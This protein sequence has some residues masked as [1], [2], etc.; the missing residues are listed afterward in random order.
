MK[1]QHTKTSWISRR[2]FAVGAAAGLASFALPRPV[3][4]QSRRVIAATGIDAFFT[5]FPIARDHKLFEKQG[6]DFTYRTFE[7]STIGLD[8]VL[9]NNADMGAATPSSGI[10]RWDRGGKLY[11]VGRMN[12]S[13]TLYA[14]AGSKD[15]RQPEDLYGK[16]VAFPRL[17]SGEYFFGKYVDFHKLDRSKIKTKS[18]PPPETVA[19]MARGDIDAIFLWEP[20]PSKVEEL[21]KGARILSRSE[22]IGL[23]FSVY[24]YFSEA[25]LQDQARSE[26]AMRALIEGA[27]F[28]QKNKAAAAQAAEKAFKLP[29][30]NAKKAVDSLNFNVEMHRD[31]VLAEYI[32]QAEFLLKGGVIKQI[33]NWDA[34]LQP[35]ILKA[36]AAD[37]VSGW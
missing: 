5:L 14:V 26:A 17:S 20:W 15:V 33:P 24:F 1:N 12:S 13:G 34:F 19:A 9:T 27:E 37:R 7:D 28:C 11:A 8:A 16:T 30:E 25:M 32:D 18:L 36:V 4:S 3:L 23:R 31:Q 6:L 10:A 29:A 35:Q 2:N 22:D 21:V